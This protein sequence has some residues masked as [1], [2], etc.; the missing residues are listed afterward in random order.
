MEEGG[1]TD[2]QFKA[3]IRK[4]VILLEDIESA[5][6]VEQAKAKIARLKQSLQQDLEG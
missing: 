1:M 3:Y 6:T 2:L 5:E 4:L